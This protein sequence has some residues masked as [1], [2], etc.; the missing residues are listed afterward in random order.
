MERALAVLNELEQ[1]TFSPCPTG[2]PKPTATESNPLIAR[3]LAGKEA[4]RASLARLPFEE[5]VRIVVELQKIAFEM[6]TAAGKPARKPW[7]LS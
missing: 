4:H 3:L 5:K 7:T 1:A 2:R 6:R